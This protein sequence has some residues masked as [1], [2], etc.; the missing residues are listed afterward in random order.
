MQEPTFLGI[1]FHQSHAEEGMY[2][3]GYLTRFLQP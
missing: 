2:V 3:A 1:E